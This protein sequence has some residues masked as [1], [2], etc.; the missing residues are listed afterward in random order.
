MHF[1]NGQGSHFLEPQSPRAFG[2]FTKKGIN[3]SK[4][5][6][7]T[8]TWVAGFSHFQKKRRTGGRVSLAHCWWLWSDLNAQSLKKNGYSYDV[9]LWSTYRAWISRSG[10]K[11]N[12][13]QYD[14]CFSSNSAKKFSLR[15]LLNVYIMETFNIPFVCLPH[16]L[17]LAFG[18]KLTFDRWLCIP[19]LPC[20]IS[21]LLFLEDLAVSC[22]PDIKHISRASICSTSG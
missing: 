11:N 8:W 5:V 16:C 3:I 12:S 2:F 22:R 14:S 1:W 15:K 7:L 17:L 21:S 6:L 10:G 20:W 9:L 18:W 19:L 4:L 13:L